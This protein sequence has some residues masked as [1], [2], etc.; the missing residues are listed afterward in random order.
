[1]RRS[2]RQRYRRRQH[3]P[4]IP[5]FEVVP[6]KRLIFVAVGGILLV[7]V[8][9]VDEQWGLTFLHVTAGAAWTIIA[10]FMGFVIGPTL[11]NMSIP[12]RIE[13]P[14]K[15]FIYTSGITG[16][17]QVATLIGMTRVASLWAKSTSCRR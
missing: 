17:M 15:S 13:K 8:I 16:L 7:V 3:P 14:M 6:L 4:A 2:H 9:A 12:A 1:M 11:E 10:L 5:A